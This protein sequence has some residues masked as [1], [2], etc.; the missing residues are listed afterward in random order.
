MR[1]AQLRGMDVSNGE[2]IGVSLFVQGCHFHCK[3]C[4]NSDTWSFEGGYAWTQ[5]LEEYLLKLLDRPYIQRITILGGEPLADDNLEDIFE[6]VKKIRT[7]VKY[8]SIWLY[9]GFTWEDIFYPT[10]VEAMSHQQTEVINQ[11]KQTTAMCDVLIDGRY[12]D[13]QKD[14]TLKWRGSKNQRIIN[15]QQSLEKGEIVLWKT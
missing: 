1:Y 8:K 5:E 10:M 7:T 4:F 15:I 11:R 12:L 3:N 14:I 2:G 9:S 13:N 6:L